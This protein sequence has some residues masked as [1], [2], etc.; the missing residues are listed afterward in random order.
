MSKFSINKN[1]LFDENH[2]VLHY[3]VYLGDQWLYSIPL[4]SL[5]EHEYHLNYGRF[6]NY[7]KE[8]QGYAVP[9]NFDTPDGAEFRYK[10]KEIVEWVA[11]H[12]EDAWNFD[13]AVQAVGKIDIIF[14]FNC[15]TVAVIFKMVWWK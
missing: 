3:D 8:L 7:R 9:L 1:I 2:D 15:P 12:S 4:L 5:Y 11:Q 10:F 13:L 6:E 14:S